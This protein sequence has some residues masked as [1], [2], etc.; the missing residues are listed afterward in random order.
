MQRG[1]SINNISFYYLILGPQ[2]E[3]SSLPV[4]GNT[5]DQVTNTGSAPIQ[6]VRQRKQV[7]GWTGTDLLY[8]L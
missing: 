2:V 8:L 4:S 6:P 1:D 3:P 7:I 5:K